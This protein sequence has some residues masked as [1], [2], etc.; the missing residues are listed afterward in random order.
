MT[1]A[2]QRKK[3]CFG[4]NGASLDNTTPVNTM[5]PAQAEALRLGFFPL[6]ATS[7]RLQGLWLFSTMER[8]ER[9]GL[10]PRQWGL[11]VRNETHGLLQA[12]GP[13]TWG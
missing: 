6:A 3:E 4:L 9:I 1:E 5:V 8:E 2:Q 12:H 10:V 7:T 13:F 11:R